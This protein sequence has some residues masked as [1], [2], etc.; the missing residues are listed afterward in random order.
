M[1]TK[2][3]T[4]RDPAPSTFAAGSS[5]TAVLSSSAVS[6]GSSP[7][8]TVLRASPFP[9]GAPYRDDVA[10]LVSAGA[11]EPAFASTSRRTSARQRLYALVASDR[12]TAVR[13]PSGPP[14]CT[15]R[16]KG[17]SAVV[18]PRRP[19]LAKQGPRRRPRGRCAGSFAPPRYASS[20]RCEP[21]R[22]QPSRDS[23]CCFRR[24]SSS[25]SP[26]TMAATPSR[27]AAAGR[28]RT[29]WV[30]ALG[31][32]LGW[33][34][35]RERS[36]AGSTVVLL[37]TGFALLTLLSALWSTND[38]DAFSEFN[39]VSFYLGV[40]VL[41]LQVAP[42][43]PLHRLGDGSCA[44]GRRGRRGRAVQPHRAWRPHGSRVRRS[45]SRD[46]ATPE[47]PD[48]V[49]ER[50]GD[51]CGARRPTAAA[52]VRLAG[53]PVSPSARGGASAGGRSHHLPRFVTRRDGHRGDW[54]RGLPG[55][56]PLPL[57]GGRRACRC[58]CRVSARAGGARLAIGVRERAGRGVRDDAS[59]DGVGA[60]RRLL[61]R[62]RPS[63]RLLRPSWIDTLRRPA[64]SASPQRTAA[65]AA[66]CGDRCRG[67]R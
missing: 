12:P 19:H 15:D 6:T 17:Y 47:L 52:R 63:R 46:G 57:E 23:A 26:T 31:A 29:W 2:S 24:C 20:A 40:F 10:I 7:G 36:R 13:R 3:Q 22:R 61:R 67:S 4:S 53:T 62:L 37:L 49:L 38:A 56:Q 16:P 39:R 33:W 34:P 27:A 58:R 5:S 42:R 35:S 44:R 18:S 21:H 25:L 60:A 51:P 59:F 48:R 43:V 14:R 50:P 1:K 45:A 54:R 32:V 64:G 65:A 8:R 66:V 11:S 9:A 28:S 30:L 55:A 41:A